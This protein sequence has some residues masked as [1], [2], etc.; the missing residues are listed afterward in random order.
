VAL[1]VAYD[2]T[3]YHGFARQPGE[4]RT[5]GGELGMALE[6]MA[7]GPVE[8]VCA[9]RT[10]AGVHATGQ[11]VHVDLPYRLFEG[12]RRGVPAGSAGWLPRALSRQLDGSVVVTAAAFAP[13]GFDAR[14]SAVAR[15]YR[16]QVL[17]RPVT[18]PLLGRTAWHVAEPLD[19]NAMRIA[20]DVLLGEHD[21]S[22]FCRRPPGTDPGA[23]T[24][25][26]VT[27]AAWRV[28]GDPDG[29]LRFEIEANAFCHQMVR[30]LVGALVAAGEGRLDGARILARLRSGDRAGLPSPAPACGLCLVSVSYPEDP[31]AG[32]PG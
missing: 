32:A 18:D 28:V 22:A 15:R 25:R 5:V 31:F 7:G 16:Y 10:D 13:E 6:K 19:L 3:G 23:P 4:V 11:V 26:R 12:R 1:R 21:F 14:R 17:N 27:S 20:A 2:G 30:S 24:V 29:L 8:L 9:G